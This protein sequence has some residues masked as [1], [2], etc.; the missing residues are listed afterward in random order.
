MPNLTTF[1]QHSNTILSIQSPSHSNQISIK[2]IQIG[3]EEVKPSLFTD[4]L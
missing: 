2:D 3:K 1:I 4:D